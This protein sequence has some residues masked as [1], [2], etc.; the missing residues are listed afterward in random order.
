[1][2]FSSVTLLLC[3]CPSRISEWLSAPVDIEAKLTEAGGDR[4]LR[5]RW[6][7]SK[8]GK[9]TTKII[10]GIMV[11]LVKQAL[12]NLRR[13]GAAAREVAR[14]YED[15]P[16]QLWLPPELE[17][18]RGQE[19]ISM[20]DARKILGPWS[21][22]G[23]LKKEGVRLERRVHKRFL[24]FADLERAV[25]S[26]LPLG[27]PIFDVTSGIKFS[28]A[29]CVSLHNQLRAKRVAWSCSIDRVG[30]DQ[31]RK[32]DGACEPRIPSMFSRF[33]CREEDGTPIRLQSHM[34]R[35]YSNTI[36][37]KAGLSDRD[38][39]LWSD[40]ETIKRND[41]YDLESPR[42]MLAR[43]RSKVADPHTWRGSLATLP[44]GLPMTREEFAALSIPFAHV[45]E[46]G[47]CIHDFTMLPCSKRRKCLRCT[48]HV[49]VKGEK[50]KTETIRA[51]LIEAKRL[52]A[53]AEAAQDRKALGANRW[54][55]F[56][57]DN[58][59]RLESL[60]GILEDPEV[61]AGTAIQLGSPA[62][63]LPPRLGL[64]PA[65]ESPPV[66]PVPKPQR[67]R[68]RVGQ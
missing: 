26:T 57:T 68:R 12:Q 29:L 35:R 24:K 48:E 60:L 46:L 43:L 65:D 8:R 56:H 27:F 49:C 10:P 53:L 34:L 3:S 9:P 18:I 31:L 52:A 20:D 15:H 51:Q 59:A 47:Y 17:R 7:P 39:Q 63:P 32:Q 4:F 13:I 2:A 61:P 37:K 62:H 44:G 42:D 25:L 1:M 66:N 36:A 54:F 11:D 30:E 38:I 6:Q 58:I 21:V 28:E 5:L 16:G 45:T 67:R 22:L 55:E 19:F 23:F 41:P 14:W 40:R 50:E 64:L 33:G